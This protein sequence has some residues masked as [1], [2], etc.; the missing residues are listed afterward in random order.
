MLRIVALVI[1]Y[2]QA[3]SPTFFV[4]WPPYVA[5]ARSPQAEN[6]LRKFLLALPSNFSS[7]LLKF[8]SLRLGGMGWATPTTPTLVGNQ[9]PRAPRA[10]DRQQRA[11]ARAPRGFAAHVPRRF[12]SSKTK[13]IDQKSILPTKLAS[14]FFEK[15]SQISG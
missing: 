10:A 13:K 8:L 14:F 7:P 11:R 1:T 6:L 9:C 2:G 12:F 5:S 3:S 15:R 4:W